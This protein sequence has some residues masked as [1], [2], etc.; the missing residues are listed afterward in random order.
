MSENNNNKFVDSFNYYFNMSTGSVISIVGLIGNLLV[1]FIL[2]RKQFRSV[3]MFRYYSFVTAIE[4]LQILII[5]VYNFPHFFYFNE[6]ELICKLIQFFSNLLGVFVTWISPV[7]SIDRYV[8]VKCPNKFLFRNKF[9]FQLTLIA[10]LLLAS[11]IAS[12]PLYYFDKI[13]SVANVTQCG[14]NENPWTGFT[15]NIS[16]LV[17]SIFVPF[18]ISITFSCLTA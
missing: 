16:L 15:I 18:T 7:I 13:T 17:L 9:K 11:S 2:T 6:N 5:W 12:I 8:G 3:S 10:C 14:Y 1:L 4:T